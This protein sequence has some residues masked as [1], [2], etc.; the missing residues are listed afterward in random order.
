M[1]RLLGL[2][3]VFHAA[4]CYSFGQRFDGQ[5]LTASFVVAL[6]AFSVFRLFGKL[7]SL[8]V[9][10]RP[11]ARDVLEQVLFK[12][13][14]QDSYTLR[15]LTRNAIVFGGTGSGKTTGAGFGIGSAIA[16]NPS[17]SMLIL[18][19]KIEDK[20]FWGGIFAA[21]K[22]ELVV[23]EPGGGLCFNVLDAELKEGG[24][25]RDITQ[26]LLTL[27]EGL[28]RGDGD[29]H[30]DPFWREANRRMLHNAIEA[31]K[32]ATGRV[33]PWDLQRFITG[34]ARSPAD[35][36]DD[37][38]KASFHN[39]VLMRACHCEKTALAKHD[40]ELARLYWTEEIPTLN[41][42][43]RTSIEAGVLGLLH[44]LNTG[45]VRELIA[46]ETN[47]TP[48]ILDEGRSILINMP[49]VA[50]DATA[51]FVNVA[52]KYA[53][54]RRILRRKAGGDDRVIV[55]WTDEYQKVANSYDAAY[56]AECRSHRGSLVALTQS[57][58]GMYE[59]MGENPSNS[60]LSNYL[61]KI[62]HAVGDAKTAELGV[63]LLGQ[64][65]ETM[66]GG[67]E[68]PSRSAGEEMCG[69]SGFNSSFSSQ[70]QPILQS[71]AFSTGLATGGP[72][73]WIAEA[74]VI[75]SGQPFSSG[76]AWHR[77][78]FRQPTRRR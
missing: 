50:G 36:K 39:E 73:D 70:Y 19:S 15:D 1:R 55:V 64:R 17:T 75:R 37:K 54:E 61:Y 5:A 27:A 46:G 26:C 52:W 56:L 29:S 22:R 51:T 20:E 28:G 30:R 41:D 71:N 62:F 23:V 48:A 3:G 47:I 42:R 78:A 40:F 69:R 10:R 6:V 11:G 9:K 59:A 76:E 53:V 35:L 34:A 24:Q 12:W 45:I 38:W 60:L 65:Q 25:T 16:R 63:A 32:Q 21:A 14:E 74:I 8:G 7:G 4:M 49:I 57:V 58:H 18:A 66:T 43:T 77:A 33:D 72:P 67:S 13:T 31:L 2:W 68:D 44:V